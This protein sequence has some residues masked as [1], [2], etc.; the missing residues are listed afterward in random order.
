MSRRLPTREELAIWRAH[1]ETFEIVRARIESRLQQDS[2]LSSGDY[3]VLLAL[4]EAKGNAMRSSELAAHIEWERSRLSGQLGRMEK[5]GLVRR[6]PCAEDARGARVV[7]TEEGSRA[8]HA[9]T[10]PHLRAV[11]EVFVDA[12]TPAQLAQLGEA[13]TAMRR[14]L[15]LD[16]RP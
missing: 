4:S 13:A 2:Q 11:K 9:S 3:R 12:F 14:H 5:R 6:E 7:L 8:F 10:R 15:D 1:L 16:A